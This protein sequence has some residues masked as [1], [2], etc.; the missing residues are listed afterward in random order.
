MPVVGAA[1]LRAGAARTRE[2]PRDISR[3]LRTARRDAVRP[4]QREIKASAAGTLPKRGGYAAVMS[5]A[6]KVST[7]SRTT[8]LTIRIFAAGRAELRDVVRVNQGE[9]RHPVFGR[10]RVTSKGPV[11]NPWKPTWVTRGF[12]DRPLDLFAARLDRETR[13]AIDRALERT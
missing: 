8:S 1:G 7:R 5:R 4:L 11:K 2:K 10:F 13:E 12:V 9:L 3:E 6:V